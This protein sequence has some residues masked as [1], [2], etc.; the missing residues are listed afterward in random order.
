MAQITNDSV[1][2]SQNWGVSFNDYVFD[3]RKM[4]FQDLMVAVAEKRAVAVEGEVA[5]MATRIQNRNDL[6]EDLGLALSELTSAQATLD[7]DASGDDKCSY[8][9]SQEA[10]DACNRAYGMIPSDNDSKK[11]LEYHIQR[12]KS[13]IDALN[14]AAQTDM[15]RLQS[16]VDRRDESYTTAS[17]LMSAVSD[18]RANLIGN[19]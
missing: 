9:F 11:W 2:L 13:T 16:L 1:A 4:D 6:L 12:V 19:L 10:K 17:T 18:T 14:N 7:S 3:G 5:P 8:T 15:S